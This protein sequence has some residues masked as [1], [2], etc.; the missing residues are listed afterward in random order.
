M[1]LDAVLL[2]LLSQIRERSQLR[3]R[4]VARRVSD[5]KSHEKIDRAALKE[6]EDCPAPKPSSPPL[7]SLVSISHPLHH[8]C[9][10]TIQLIIFGTNN[11]ANPVNYFAIAAPSSTGDQHNSET[12]TMAPEDEGASLDWRKHEDKIRHLFIS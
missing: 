6:V 12:R 5:G 3:C 8:L 9:D 4:K 1:G 10:P 7:F 2:W 11:L